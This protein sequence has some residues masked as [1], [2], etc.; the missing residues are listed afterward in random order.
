[1]TTF[2]WISG[3]LNVLLILKGINNFFKKED[4]EWD[5][6]DTE[7][8]YQWLLINIESRLEKKEYESIK[9]ILK[10]KIYAI[11]SPFDFTVWEEKPWTYHAK[12]ENWEFFYN[13]KPTGITLPFGSKQQETCDLLN[14][15][16]AFEERTA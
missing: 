3:I 5:V 4:L 1:M 6:S 2:L 8:K 15:N 9:D 12:N 14:E 16:A 7:K 13:R 11:R 10:E